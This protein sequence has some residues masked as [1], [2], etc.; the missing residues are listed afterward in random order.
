MQALNARTARGG[1]AA[2]VQVS[3]ARTHF[4]FT[5]EPVRYLIA[6]IPPRG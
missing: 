1:V 4:G 5:D 6:I 3:I 2:A